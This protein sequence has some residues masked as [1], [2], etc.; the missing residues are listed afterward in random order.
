MNQEKYQQVKRIF[1]WASEHAP[2]ERPRL[3]RELSGGDETLRLA[4]ESLLAASEKT[5]DFMEQAAIAQVAE[6]IVA[7]TESLIVGEKLGRYSVKSSLGA[8]GMG[9]VFLAEDTELER[10]VA[11]KVLSDEF[12]RDD[13]RIRRFV[14]EAKAASA[15]N[16]P[17]ILTVYE[18][19]R[20][21]D[22]HFI[23]AEFIIGE[24]LR[25][26]LKGE[27]LNLREILD[28]ASQTAAALNAAHRS[29]IIHRDIKPENIMLRDDGFVK[30]LD[31]GLAKLVETRNEE[32]DTLMQASEKNP[33]FA[34]RTPHLT[35]PGMIMGTVA[36]MSPEQTRGTETDAR[37][38]IWS[39]GVVLYEML[40]GRL[41]FAG[42]TTADVTASII[43]SEPAPLG[44]NTPAE[45]KRIVRKALQKNRD[46][47][48]QTIKD[49]LLDL[50]NLKHD[51]EFSEELE[52]T[53]Q[54]LESRASNVGTTAQLSGQTTTPQ[55]AVAITENQSQRYR[56]SGI[57]SIALVNRRSFLTGSV[58]LLGLIVAAASFAF[59]RYA[60]GGRTDL[61]V[62]K[63]TALTNTGNILVGAISPDG[64]LLATVKSDGE[65]QGLWLRYLSDKIAELPLILPENQ[66]LKGLKFTPDGSQI[67][68]LTTNKNSTVSR[69]VALPVLGGEPRMILENIE[70]PPAFS[71][72]GNLFA[73]IRADRERGR[74]TLFVANRDGTEVREIAARTDPAFYGVRPLA[75]S[76]DGTAVICIGKNNDDNQK[77]S[78]IEVKLDDGQERILSVQPWAVVHS[79]VWTKEKDGLIVSTD[80]VSRVN[81]NQLWFLP[82]PTG[83]ARQITSDL[84]EYV[85][86]SLAAQ[87]GDLIAVNYQ[88]R[89]SLGITSLIAPNV[90]NRISSN[91]RDGYLG[92]A[93]GA[94]NRIFYTSL[95]DG[96]L[97]VKS[98]SAAGGNPTQILVANLEPR[99]L[100]ATPDGSFVI[101]S[102]SQNGR[103]N[104]WRMNAD[105]KNLQRLTDGTRD[106]FPVVSPDGKSVIY[107]SMI[108]SQW[109]CWRVPVEGGQ[110][111]KVVHAI[112]FRPQVSSDGKLIAG[113]YR[114]EE[115]AKAQFATFAFGGDVPLQT[116]PIPPSVKFGSLFSW[117]PD[118]KGLAVIDTR[119]GIENL[120]T[121]PLNEESP[122]PLTNFAPDLLPLTIHNFGWSPDKTA[123]TLAR[124]SN[125]VDVV[126]IA[127]Q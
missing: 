11:V 118:G 122:Q 89:S 97:A 51:L 18:I 49:F 14:Q 116:V 94:D 92:L 29:R 81:N 109:S 124:G 30:V 61:A 59:Y 68:Y 79:M 72:D 95:V 27:P 46:E 127:Y 100:V 73:F 4:V 120:W 21:D 10:L 104:L 2:A 35:A 107:N 58:I 117:T 22:L 106:E 31:F 115:N 54:T 70:T 5:D 108:G 45:L 110:A 42:A 123:L 88:D 57:K 50:K 36:Y 56:T 77:S 90:F 24:T 69:L 16:H 32:A 99:Q 47:R 86:V 62:E 112:L 76:P 48:Y 126:K 125:V 3:I 101:F 65:K 53:H 37:S 25:Q 23:A 1:Q 9:E 55:D 71:P 113:Y 96:A 105:G 66:T 44:E 91:Q 39:L 75:F 64:K 60:G 33:H 26:R 78:V 98:V 121:L 15:L 114:P 19:G 52:R 74:S 80:T 43:K 12:S 28:I 63:I 41:P 40:A 67:Y 84:S 87:T 85:N 6:A 103:R 13:E 111:E 20:H 34:L 17:N 38:D 102:S 93:Y 7:K 119:N 8:G 82:V 83:E